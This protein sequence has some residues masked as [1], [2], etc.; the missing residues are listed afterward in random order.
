METR[1]NSYHESD[2]IFFSL[3]SPSWLSYEAESGKR[4]ETEFGFQVVGGHAGRGA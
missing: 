3:I 2:T 4:R 1:T